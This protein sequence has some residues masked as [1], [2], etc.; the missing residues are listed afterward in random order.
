MQISKLNIFRY[1]IPLVK[2]LKLLGVQMSHREGILL[3]LESNCGH[4][5]WGEIAP[6]PGLH[7][8]ALAEAEAQTISLRRILADQIIPSD[9]ELLKGE[10]ENR[11]SANS[12]LPS[13]RYGFEMALLNLLSTKSNQALC[14]FLSKKPRKSVSL[15]ALLTG[16]SA[17]FKDQ[18]QSI[19][20]NGY[21]AVKLKVGRQNIE[22]DIA[23]VTTAK[24]LLPAYI[25]LRLD[26]NRAWDFEEAMTFGNAVSNF[27]IE[28]LEEP[29][30]NPLHLREFFQTTGVPLALDETLWHAPFQSSQLFPGIAALILKPAILG[31]FETIM[32]YAKLAEAHQLK[33]VISSAFESGVGLTA[34]ANIAASINK[35]DIPAGL[36]TYQW[37]KADVLEN[38]F[39]AVHGKIDL[40]AV[41][42]AGKSILSERL[43]G[44][45]A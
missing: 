27:D 10:F 38:A 40:Q 44:V 4:S 17:T 14:N 35:Q 13:V 26:A 3:K 5:G 15:N 20:K 36:D 41:N 21:K 1:S 7:R 28:Y 24:K 2:P 8:E 12:L 33:A 19:V 18:I 11:L 30:K 22:D 34:A 29:L 31:S 16:N 32:K 45:V 9:T 37:L 23:M 39:T 43:V 6:F 25:S 42:R